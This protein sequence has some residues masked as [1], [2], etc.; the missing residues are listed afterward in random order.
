[1]KGTKVAVCG[2]ARDCAP[3]LPGNIKKIERLRKCFQASYVV[4][5]E[6]DSRDRTKD[7]LQNWSDSRKDV[8]ILSEDTGERTIP[9]QSPGQ[10][11]PWF[12]RHRIERLAKF[13]NK[14]L[15]YVE[16]N[17]AVDALVLL[18]LDVFSFSVDGI[19]NTFGQPI[20][21]HAV[22]ANGK[23]IPEGREFFN[24]YMYYDGYA[25]KETADT[26]PQTEEMIFGYQNIFKGLKPG[27][28]MVR[29]ASAFNGLAVYKMDAVR[30]ARYCCLVNKDPHVEAACDHVSLHQ[31]MA[32]RGHDLIYVN[33]AQIVMYNT[34]ANWLYRKLRKFGGKVRGR[35]AGALAAAK[36]KRV[37]S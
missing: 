16:N 7:I 18:D 5:V 11:R 34:Y 26:R 21:W 12:S 15:D 23:N 14:Y 35:L 30:G 36:N 10:V 1:M 4:V 8:F 31:H 28:P 17:L 22:T 25:L 27:M 37:S 3:N 24:G 33:P 6:N 19:A 13:R 20:P 9:E 2:L 29:V 32:E